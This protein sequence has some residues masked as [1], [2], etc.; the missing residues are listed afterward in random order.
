MSTIKAVLNYTFDSQVCQQ[1]FYYVNVTTTPTNLLLTQFAE[2]WV[3]NVLDDYIA[4]LVDGVVFNTLD[5]SSNNIP[6]AF[7]YSLGAATGAVV[8]ADEGEIPANIVANIAKTVSGSYD[9]GSG[10]PYTGLRPIRSG[11]FYL[12]GLPK[13]LMSK[14]GV[15]TG[16]ATYAAFTALLAAQ[17]TPINAGGSVWEPVVLGFPLPPRGIS[18]TYP[19]GLPARDYVVADITG[20]VFKGWTKL[21]TREES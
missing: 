17:A 18:P 20:A 13:T 16:A 12:S 19:S 21:E 1:T 10:A 7:P 9:P 2:D 4:A 5:V 3:D 11:R 6:F 14:S 15:N 8:A